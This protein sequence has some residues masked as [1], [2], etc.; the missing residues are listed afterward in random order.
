MPAPTNANGLSL[1][2][3]VI[4]PTTDDTATLKELLSQHYIG[5][6][7]PCGARDG[8]DVYMAV[9]A[10]SDGGG[11]HILYGGNPTD[12]T[13]PHVLTVSASGSATVIWQYEDSTVGTYG[14]VSFEGA[15]VTVTDGGTKAIVTIPGGGGGGS[16][17]SFETWAVTGGGS[18]VADSATDTATFTGGTGITIT[19]TAGSD[20][21]EFAID[22][23]EVAQHSFKT[24]AVSGQDPVVADSPTDT[25]TLVAGSNVTITTVEGTDTITIASTDTD[26]TYT[27]GAGVN[28]GGIKFSADPNNASY[29]GL[30]DPSTGDDSTADDAQIGI[31]WHQIANYD[32]AKN[33]LI[34]HA[35]GDTTKPVI[36]YKTVVDWLE[37]LPDWSSTIPLV[38]I[39]DGGN[40]GNEIRWA[41]ISE[42]LSLLTG[43][44]L[45]NEQ[46]I[47][48]DSGT[49]PEWQDDTDACP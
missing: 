37:T 11:A 23:S 12:P 40:D 41:T 8:D 22:T 46:S 34:G 48:K 49:G 10:Q 30:V 32:S 25:L 45:A 4:D 28:L 31:L 6:G 16:S 24:V 26:T 3:P 9:Y 44:T 38:L 2:R 20:T 42:M 1:G 21:L 15:G 19:A 47:G 27:A 35:A 17:N 29:V 39:S 5:A 7:F 43:Y 33:M 36:E 13:S 18:I 14:T